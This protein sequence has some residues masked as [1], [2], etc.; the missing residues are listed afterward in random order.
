MNKFPKLIALLGLLSLVVSLSSTTFP[1]KETVIYIVRHAEK[2]TSDPANNNPALSA[3]GKERAIA[4]NE[5]LR[6]EKVAAVFS[7]NYKR[8]MQ[9]ASA[10]AQR[11]GVPLKTYKDAKEVADL[12][13]S[14]FT[15]QKILITGH[16]NTILDIVKAFGATPPFDKLND[17]DYDLIFRV[18]I[19]KDGEVNLKTR[20][21]GKSH[22][23]TPI[24]E[25]KS[26]P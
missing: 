22:H 9:T 14:E 8:T 3:E 24:P 19:G 21:F 7:T 15:N 23:S 5:F 13:K 26:A 17:D 25:I 18:E 6:K 2:D 10:V 20:R 12:V 11:N 4:L 1:A 16:S